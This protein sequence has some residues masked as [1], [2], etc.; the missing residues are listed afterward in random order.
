MYDLQNKL[1]TIRKQLADQKT[2]TMDTNNCMQFL[3]QNQSNQDANQP[4][5]LGQE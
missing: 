4:S 5:Q 1:E 2:L 3:Q